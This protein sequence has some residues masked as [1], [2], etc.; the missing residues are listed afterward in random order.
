MM[1]CETPE[2]PKCLDKKQRLALPL[3]AVAL[4]LLAAPLWCVCAVPLLSCLGN[5]LFGDS[6][7]FAARRRRVPET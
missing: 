7:R 5:C 6:W 1:Y 4:V 2:A 3:W